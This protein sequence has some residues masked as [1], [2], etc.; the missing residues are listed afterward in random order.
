MHTSVIPL[1]K[2]LRHRCYF[3]R[4]LPQLPVI[5]NADSELGDWPSPRKLT[6]IPGI[7]WGVDLSKNIRSFWHRTWPIVL[8]LIGSLLLCGSQFFETKISSIRNSSQDSTEKSHS[9]HPTQSGSFRII[10]IPPCTSIPRE[11]FQ[12]PLTLM[13]AFLPSSP[14]VPSF[15]S[16]ASPGGK[17]QQQF[18]SGP[19]KSYQKWK[20]PMF[21]TSNFLKNHIFGN[22]GCPIFL[23]EANTM[24]KTHVKTFMKSHETGFRPS[25]QRRFIEFHSM[26]NSASYL[27]FIASPC[28]GPPL[29]VNSTERIKAQPMK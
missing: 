15:F 13:R 1:S 5:S 16:A 22:L 6:S 11:F 8:L 20:V 27:A 2:V 14:P 25:F 17:F 28:P 7:C 10:T 18:L 21:W 23:V 3:W 19:A 29:P 4:S 12:T 9:I 26:K 24:E